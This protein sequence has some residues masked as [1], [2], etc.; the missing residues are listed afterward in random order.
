MEDA[1]RVTVIAT[2][3][4]EQQTEVVEE[5]PHVTELKPYPP[6]PASVQVATAE[7]GTY[8]RKGRKVV[9]SQLPLEDLSEEVLDIPTFLRRQAD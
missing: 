5:I 1:V 4:D 2:G 7:R 8:L 9:G 3:F 6:K